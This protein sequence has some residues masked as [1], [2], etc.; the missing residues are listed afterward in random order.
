MQ[1]RTVWL[2]VCGLVVAC[3]SNT[4]VNN[5]ATCGPG[6]MPVNGICE[7]VAEAGTDATSA[8][9][10]LAEGGDSGGTSKPDGG[11]ALDAGADAGVIIGSACTPVDE[12]NPHFTGFG[13][14]GIQV[15]GTGSGLPACIIDRFQGLTTC[16]YG[17]SADGQPP[18]GASPCATPTGQPVVGSVSAQCSD[19]QASQVVFWSCRCANLGG[20]TD[21][22]YAYCTCPAGMT[23]TQLLP[24]LGD[25]SA[26]LSGAYC[27]PPSA[28]LPDGGLAYLC[29]T[30]CSPSTAPCP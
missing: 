14:Y 9:S 3:G 10:G 30:Q 7:V 19:R 4:T 11:A 25:A 23:C 24:S 21:D 22:G 8:D 18:V 29:P 20:V 15:D 16:P 26:G 17:Q 6:T 27:V 1:R 13:L 2:L 5:I 28:A 12:D